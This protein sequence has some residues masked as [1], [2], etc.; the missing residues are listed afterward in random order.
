MSL[1]TEGI[2]V[3]TATGN[4]ERTKCLQLAEIRRLSL[5]PLFETWPLPEVGD[6]YCLYSEG[7][8]RSIRQQC[9]GIC[10]TEGLARG[11]K[12]QA[13]IAREMLHKHDDYDHTDPGDE[14]TSGTGSAKMWGLTRDGDWIIV[15]VKFRFDGATPFKSLH[16]SG[17]PRFAEP[18]PNRRHEHPTLVTARVATPEEMCAELCVHPREFCGN[19]ANVLKGRQEY[20]KDQLSRVDDLVTA[21]E[22]EDA[23]YYRRP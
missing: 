9:D 19:L 8:L 14:K 18:T 5:L 21:F 4:D 10:P 22:Y 7:K 15:V 16:A 20:L 6:V 1:H 11:L 23:I 13:I 17:R 12:T 2:A 3:L